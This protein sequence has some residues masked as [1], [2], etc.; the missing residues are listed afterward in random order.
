MV[1]VFLCLSFACFGSQGRLGSAEVKDAQRGAGRQLEGTWESP[2]H[3]VE[4]G[5]R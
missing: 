1:K 5:E 4:S 3:E 2:P